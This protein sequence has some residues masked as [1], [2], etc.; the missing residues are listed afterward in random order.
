[1]QRQKL[2]LQKFLK[3]NIDIALVA[4]TWLA[5][6]D[7]LRIPDYEII[8]RDRTAEDGKT[9][10]R[11][12]LIAIYKEIPVEDTIQP[13]TTTIETAAIRTRTTP[14]LTIGTAC[15]SAQQNN[16]N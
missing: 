13:T 8:R 11:G 5:P 10:R 15:T 9:P 7:M 1:H 12:I 6:A 3:D 14:S 2:E 4:D 16:S